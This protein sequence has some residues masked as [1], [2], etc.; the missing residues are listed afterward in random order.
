MRYGKVVT[1]TFIDRPNRF[2]ADVLVG[3]EDGAPEEV[4]RCH[5]KNT[6][7]CREILVPGARVV[8]ERSDSPSRKTP[9]DL[10]AAYKGDMLVNIDSQAP[11]KAFHEYILSSGIFGEDPKASRSACTVTPA[12]TST[13]NRA[14]GGSSPR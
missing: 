13:W 10:V 12:S 9:Y 14:A 6:G 5:V 11:N 3:G 7:R 8:L 4:A 2:I 1:G